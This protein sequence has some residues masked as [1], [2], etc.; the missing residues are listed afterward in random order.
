MEAEQS[1][2]SRRTSDSEV[3]SQEIYRAFPAGLLR[4]GNT[5]DLIRAELELERQSTF[6]HPEIVEL[7]DYAASKGIP[8]A[9]GVRH[10]F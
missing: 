4:N 7:I 9:F 8:A 6:Y 2:R 3:G 10:V 5:A 1:A